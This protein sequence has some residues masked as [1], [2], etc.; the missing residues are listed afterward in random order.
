ML[1]SKIIKVSELGKS[2]VLAFT[3][4]KAVVELL[5]KKS[6]LYLAGVRKGDIILEVNKIKITDI[7]TLNRI[8]DQLLKGTPLKLR[9][10]DSSGNIKIIDI[11][12]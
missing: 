8:K 10:R 2:V 11:I 4:N 1:L 6:A 3:Q 7:C 9:C 12:L 5:D